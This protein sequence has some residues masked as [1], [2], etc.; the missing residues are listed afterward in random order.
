MYATSLVVW[1][2]SNKVLTEVELEVYCELSVRVVEV[3]EKVS[4]TVE[5]VPVEY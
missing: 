3:S 1:M 2:L 5:I 4:D